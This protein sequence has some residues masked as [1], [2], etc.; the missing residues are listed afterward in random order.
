MYLEAMN[1]LR[2]L[3]NSLPQAFEFEDLVYSRN[4]ICFVWIETSQR[5]IEDLRVEFG[6]CSKSCLRK[7]YARA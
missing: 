3:L 4:I 5:Q 7:F 6:Y 1:I 2:S